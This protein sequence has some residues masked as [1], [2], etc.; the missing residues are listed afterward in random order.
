MRELLAGFGVAS[1]RS[2][3][4]ILWFLV[5][6]HS[7]FLASAAES[8][9]RKSLSTVGCTSRWQ[10]SCCLQGRA[11]LLMSLGQDWIAQW[12]TVA[13]KGKAF[14]SVMISHR[15]LHHRASL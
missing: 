6:R 7:S 1:K 11:Y 4:K 10:I 14:S 13:K 2:A 8:G 15:I 3:G 12:C 9:I 5:T